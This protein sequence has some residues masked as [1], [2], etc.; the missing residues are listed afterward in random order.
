MIHE[1]LPCAGPSVKVLH[2]LSQP[3]LQSETLSRKNTNRITS[4]LTDRSSR[5]TTRTVIS[6]LQVRQR[7]VG[8]WLGD[9][10]V[11]ASHMAG[12]EV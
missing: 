6:V 12:T 10:L 8:D 3:G 7:G 9:W 2:L 11:C 4:R 5:N 1:R